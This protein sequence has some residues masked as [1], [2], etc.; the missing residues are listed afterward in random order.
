[1]KMSAIL[2]DAMKYIDQSQKA[3]F[4]TLDKTDKKYIINIAEFIND[5]TDIYFI[6]DKDI[7]NV[8]NDSIVN[9]YFQSKIEKYKMF[10]RICV[11]GKLTK[12]IYSTEIYRVFKA[13]GG[14]NKGKYIRNGN[15]KNYTVYKLK[16]K[17]MNL[18]NYV[19]S[20]EKLRKII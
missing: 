7:G 12:I 4:I 19:K 9:V 13:L 16:V 14:K 3:Y 6:V 11:S 18:C 2:N 1:M 5:C 20:S 15:L 17:Y 8:E 10:K